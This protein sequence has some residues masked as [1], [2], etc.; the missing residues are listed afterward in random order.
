MDIVV[1]TPRLHIFRN[2]G[3]CLQIWIKIGITLD[4]LIPSLFHFFF[5]LF[6]SFLLFWLEK[7]VEVRSCFN[8]TARL[9]PG[10]NPLRFLT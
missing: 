1:F 10:R 3:E 9:V 8:V 2:N 7:Y 5:C 4:C 6:V